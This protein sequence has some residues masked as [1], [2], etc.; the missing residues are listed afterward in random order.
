MNAK[1]TLKTKL[2]SIRLDN[3][4]VLLFRKIAGGFI[5]KLKTK[6]LNAFIGGSLAKGTM[7]KKAVQDVDVFVVFDCSED[8]L[9]L[10]G[11][12]EGVDLDGGVLRKVHG[13]RD[14]FHVVYD[15]IVLE[16]VPVVRCD[17]PERAENVTDMSLSHVDFVVGEIGKD[18]GLADEIRLAKAF[19]KANRC[20]GAEGYVHGFSG[21]SLEVLVIH[22]GGFLK[23][24]KKVGKDRVV[25]TVKHFRNRR[26][27]LREINS[28][29]LQGPLVVVDPTYRYRNI[30]AGLNSETFEGFLDSAR[31]FLRKPSLDF[32]EKQDIDIEAFRELA[33]KEKGRF[34]EVVMETDRQGGDIA[35]TKMKKMFDFFVRELER[36]GQEV[37]RKEFDYVGNGGV[38][39]GYLVVLEKSEIEVRG[40]SVGRKDAVEDFCRVRDAYRKGKFWWWKKRVCVGDVLEF[41][42]GKEDEMGAGIGIKN[43]VGN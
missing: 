3:E 9:K 12:L 17:D 34:V 11:V 28:S 43:K 29:K 35:G 27:V 19:C 21:Y 5:A 14:Y 10:G 36:S 40:P 6:G 37:L 2:D 26:E 30:C 16:I 8:I 22:Y 42:K 23:F 31:R 1:E 41:V 24:L 20:Y 38:S 25:D 18:G 33:V 15:E 4:Q 32:F 39:N 13:S 7:I